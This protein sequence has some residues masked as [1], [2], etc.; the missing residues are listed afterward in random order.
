MKIFEL[1]GDIKIND[2]QALKSI[3]KVGGSAQKL[4]GKFKTMG[5]VVGGFAIAGGAAL[6]AFAF[7]A[8]QAGANAEEMLNKYNV[9]FDGMTDTTDA[10]AENFAKS[11][12]RSE[13]ETKEMLSNLSDLQQGLGMTKEASFDLSSKIV[14]L[15]TDLAS[16]NNL[17]DAE[18]I[19]A[20]SKAMLGEAESAKRLGLL[21]NV[22][23]VK[24]YAEAQGLVYEELTDAERAQQVYN[25]AVSQSQNAIGDAARSS[26]S[27]T[28]KVKALK[29][30]FSDLTTE[31]GMKLIP[32]ATKFVDVILEKGIPAFESFT[33]WA[34]DELLPALKITFGWIRDYGIPIIKGVA[35]FIGNLIQGIDKAIQKFQ[36]FNEKRKSQNEM[37]AELEAEAQ[38]VMANPL[39]STNEVLFG[40]PQAGNVFN[41]NINAK[42]T[43][44][45]EEM[46]NITK[47]NNQQLAY[48]LGAR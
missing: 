6:G 5:K 32:Y 24:A 15:G 10:W 2:S 16:F 29:S 27:Y 47:V 11:V 7:K 35:E 1:F 12:G 36:S 23:R 40:N 38:G 18:A 22:D 45:A 37:L 14:E 33:L 30:R 26:D 13:F 42:T 19:D 43:V 39:Q 25:L 21:L 28:N 20:I 41:T 3:D 44:D 31:L 9:V 17:Q 48:M 34:G 46:A 8:V 4:G